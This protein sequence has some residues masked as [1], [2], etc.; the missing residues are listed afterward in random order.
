MSRVPEAIKS[1]AVTVAIWSMGRNSD[2]WTP[3]MCGNINWNNG[4]RTSAPVGSGRD[5]A[6]YRA[7]LVGDWHRA[8]RAALDEYMDEVALGRG[9][10]FVVSEHANLITH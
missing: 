2:G 7:R 10:V 1:G 4:V 9:N 8:L 6:Q 5:P 3:N